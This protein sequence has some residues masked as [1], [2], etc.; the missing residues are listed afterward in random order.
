MRTLEY[1]GSHARS[2]NPSIGASVRENRTIGLRRRRQAG[3]ANESAARTDTTNEGQ[4][5]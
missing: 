5:G 2:A 4:N 1:L 3:E